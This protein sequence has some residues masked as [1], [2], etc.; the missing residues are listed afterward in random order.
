MKRNKVHVVTAKIPD[1]S[2]GGQTL[3]GVVTTGLADAQKLAIRNICENWVQDEWSEYDAPSVVSF[4][5]SVKAK[6]YAKA[7]EVWGW[8]SSYQIEIEE[9]TPTKCV[10]LRGCLM[11]K[12]ELK[13]FVAWN[14][15]EKK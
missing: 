8:I 6:D 3:V 1:G 15:K 7:L 14:T 11:T 12:T 4:H 2:G 9:V 5:E 10:S 13:D